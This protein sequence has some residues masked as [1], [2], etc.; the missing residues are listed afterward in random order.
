MV[1]IAE[2]A[3][4]NR[5]RTSTFTSSGPTNSSEAHTSSDQPVHVGDGSN[6]LRPDG[7]SLILT[8]NL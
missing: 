5:L 6:R 8:V 7:A 1:D 4:L 2:R 3:F